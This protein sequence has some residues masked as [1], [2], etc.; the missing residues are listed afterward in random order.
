VKIMSSTK[1]IRIRRALFLQSMNIEES[2]W[3]QVKQ[4]ERRC[5]LNLWNQ[6]QGAFSNH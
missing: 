5:L 3:S 6:A 1:R 4:K 2:V